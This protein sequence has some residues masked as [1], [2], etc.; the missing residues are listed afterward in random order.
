MRKWA[1]KP[2]III[3]IPNMTIGKH[4]IEQIRIV[5]QTLYNRA[6]NE[7]IL[8]IVRGV[9]I[10][11]YLED[12]RQNEPEKYLVSLSQTLAWVGITQKLLSEKYTT[13]EE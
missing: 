1:W 2:F 13:L 8:Q 4:S 6:W 5:R 9:L 7:K 11:S 12:G 10:E 3:D